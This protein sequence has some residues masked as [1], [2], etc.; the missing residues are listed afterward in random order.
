MSQSQTITGTLRYL[1]QAAVLDAAS[2]TGQTTSYLLL[3]DF[4]PG[5]N[6]IL[7]QEAAA[8]AFLVNHGHKEGSTLGVDGVTDEV[9]GQPVIHVIQ[10]L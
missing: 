3:M 10:V 2:Q 8:R 4:P 6:T 7:T 9:G 5:G 1:P